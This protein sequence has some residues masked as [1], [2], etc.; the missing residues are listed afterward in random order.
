MIIFA[1]L[2]AL[3]M[4][5]FVMLISMNTVQT[6]KWNSLVV[7]FSDAFNPTRESISI[8]QEGNG[9][10][11]KEE[12]ASAT[13]SLDYLSAVFEKAIAPHSNIL[14]LHVS[15]LAD[16][17][18]ISLPSHF[19]F[20]NSDIDY[21]SSNATPTLS[22]ASTDLLKSLTAV[23]E[24]L[25]NQTAIVGHVAN[26][27]SG[28][29]AWVQSL[30]Q[31]RSVEKVI[32]NAGYSSKMTI[33]GLGNSRFADIDQTILPEVQ[34]IIANRVDIEVSERLKEAIVNDGS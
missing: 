27:Y 20:E 12:I 23:L 18:V 26:D 34:T 6:E 25:A 11:T 1:D 30:K 33:Y 2:L 8:E 32:L 7:G 31:A 5:F 3:L 9:S 21:A 17:V 22:V 4:T 29:S 19:L 24:Q 14:G 15:H 16:K 13:I 28:S 10:E